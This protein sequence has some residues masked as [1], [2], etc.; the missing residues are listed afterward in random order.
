MRTQ[1]LMLS[2][3]FMFTLW[4]FIVAYPGEMP[5]TERA[6]RLFW[7]L[8]FI[9]RPDTRIDN[10][11][12]DDDFVLGPLSF[13]KSSWIAFR[14]TIS[15]KNKD[16][17]T[18]FCYITLYLINYVFRLRFFNIIPPLKIKTKATYW[19]EEDIKRL[20]RDWYWTYYSRT[21]GFSIS[22]GYFQL[23][24][25]VDTDGDSEGKEQRW[26]C[27]IPWTRWRFV[28]H[29]LYNIE[30]NLFYTYKENSK[31]NRE[32][33]LKNNDTLYKMKEEC[34]SVCFFIQDYDGEKIIAKTTIEE[35][36][37]LKGT[38]YFKWLSYFCKPMIQ[39]TLNVEYKSEVGKDKGSWKG[40]LIGHS[41]DLIKDELHEEAFI[42][43]CEQEH[44]SK[45][46]KYKVKFLSRI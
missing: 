29:S 12:T 40:G 37:W 35:R 6:V 26:S 27:F 14:F 30:G 28:R 22:D 32:E 34:P 10:R 8:Y 16:K 31:M 46:G 33:R 3:P 38:G 43:Y 9:K 20:G 41:I 18:D 44:R 13:G 17:E 39:R 25:G 19:S 4:R 24:Y 5:K 36:E 23:F 15:S 45:H 21:Y 11:L 7:R 2:K 1:E 42:R